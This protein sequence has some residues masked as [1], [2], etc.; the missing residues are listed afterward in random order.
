PGVNVA[1]RIPVLYSPALRWRDSCLVRLNLCG[2]VTLKRWW[3]MD[4][5]VMV[6]LGALLAGLTKG[7]LGPAAGVLTTLLFSLHMPVTEAIGLALSL[8]LVS[9][10]PG[11][12]IYWRQWDGPRLRR[13]LPPAVIG[14]ALGFALLTTLPDETLRRA[15]AVLALSAMAYKLASDALGSLEYRERAWHG[16]AAGWGAGFGSALANVGAPPITIY[17]LL[18]GIQPVAFV[19]TTLYFFFLVDMMKLPLFLAAGVIDPQA[20][21]DVWWAIPVI[22]LGIWLGRELVHRIQ[23]RLYEWLLIALLTYASILLLVN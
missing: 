20:L 10:I 22:P 21:L 6:L 9:Y 13:M 19:A 8:H 2:V 12:P 14:V 15:L 16:I 1:G 11:L 18:T 7:G 4:F 23:P 17:L 3:T 5:T